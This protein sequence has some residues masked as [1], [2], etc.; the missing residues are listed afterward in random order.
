MVP[1][2]TAVY[3]IEKGTREEITSRMISAAKT[4]QTVVRLKSGELRNCGPT[5]DEI[6]ALQEAG[7]EFEVLPG[8]AA[9]A[10]EVIELFRAEETGVE[11]RN[12]IHV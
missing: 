7:I 1:S 8:D 3:S 12:D 9:E 11:A 5:Q 4:G 2:R 6:R 10:E